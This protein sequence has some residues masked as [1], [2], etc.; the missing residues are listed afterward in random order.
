MTGLDAA[1]FQTATQDAI[2]AVTNPDRIDSNL[3]MDTFSVLGKV[4]RYLLDGTTYTGLDGHSVAPAAVPAGTIVELDVYTTTDVAS[5]NDPYQP[6]VAAQLITSATPA[7]AATT[8]TAVDTSAAAAPSA[9]PTHAA[10]THTVAIS[11]VAVAGGSGLP[12]AKIAVTSADGTV[13]ADGSW[14]SKADA[15]HMLALAEGDYVFHEDAAPAGYEKVNDISFHVDVNGTVTVAKANGAEASV[16]GY[17]LEV[18]DQGVPST[19][20]TPATPAKQSTQTTS[21]TMSGHGSAVPGGPTGG[22]SSSGTTGSTGTSGCGYT[23]GSGYTSSTGSL[24]HT[25]LNDA[26]AP[27]ALGALAL[28]VG[29]LAVSRRRSEQR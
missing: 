3:T 17:T 16:S 15:V 8:P 28:G 21:S 13:V 6:L 4:Y 1:T 24:A 18:V 5:G 20:A 19:P 7:P 29:T 22:H 9:T 10:A 25:G 26:I 14:T 2:W 27:I 23:S 12:G 11:K